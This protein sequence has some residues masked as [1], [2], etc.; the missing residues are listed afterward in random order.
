MGVHRKISGFTL[1]ELLV[2]I[3]LVGITV[4][5]VVINIERDPGQIAQ[6]EAERFRS[7]VKHAQDESLLSG[8]P[9]AVEVDEAKRSYRFLEPDTPWRVITKDDVLRERTLPEGLQL[10]LDVKE[11]GPGANGHLV[12]VDGLGLITPF[13]VTISSENNQ[14]QVTVD[15]GQNVRLDKNETTPQENEI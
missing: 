3:A 14:Y 8:R 7:L 12:V 15:T 11:T 1:I 9:Y 10:R 5:L 4:T 6:L 2:V 13:V